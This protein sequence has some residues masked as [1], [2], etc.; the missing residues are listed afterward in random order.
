[1]I[2]ASDLPAVV[3]DGLGDGDEGDRE[4]AEDEQCAEELLLEGTGTTVRALLECCLESVVDSS[5][6]AADDARALRE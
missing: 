5:A 3:A 4:D 1:M 2:P 6:M